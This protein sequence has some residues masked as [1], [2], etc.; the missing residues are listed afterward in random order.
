MQGDRH[1]PCVEEFG[2]KFGQLSIKGFYWR[3]S[4]RLWSFSEES[5]R[6]QLVKRVIG[7]VRDD[8]F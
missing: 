6:D 1:G 8:E 2:C 7:E 3:L 4:R 5:Q